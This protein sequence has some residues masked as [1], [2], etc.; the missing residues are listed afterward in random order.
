MT[1]TDKNFPHSHSD[2]RHLITAQFE[3]DQ[4][5]LLDELTAVGWVRG[6]D[7]VQFL[8]GGVS[9]VTVLISSP[10]RS[11]VAKSAREFLAVGEPWRAERSRVIFEGEVL[12][13]LGGHLGRLRTPR[14][15]GALPAS[16]AI[17]M[18]AFLPLPRSWKSALLAAEVDQGVV[19]AAAVSL[20][21]MHAMPIP[22]SLPGLADTAGNLRQLRI[23]PFYLKTAE[24][25]A[26]YQFLLQELAE[27][28][29][30]PRVQR[31]VHGDFTPKNILLTSDGP[32]LVDF[33]TVHVGE[34]ALDL[35]MLIGHM[36]MK[37][38]ALGQAGG[39][40]VSAATSVFPAYAAAGGVASEITSS[41]HTGAVIL[42]RLFGL[43]RVDYLTS[44]QARDQSRELA[45]SLIRGSITLGNLADWFS[46]PSSVPTN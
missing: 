3:P 29:E 20:A 8:S 34:P 21:M 27:E 33:E 39:G 40:L 19:N 46:N 4:Q 11:F 36:C 6:D 44:T 37:A 24:R 5:Q 38:V 2:S 45:N 32:A 42:A 41:R 17:A 9:A 18:Q 43:S 31:L 26:E 7:R 16:S 30:R 35:G 23:E 15:L 28:L 22:D 13:L 14:F 1:V 25:L 10:R 12:K